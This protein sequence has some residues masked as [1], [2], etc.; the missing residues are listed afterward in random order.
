[1]QQDLGKPGTAQTLYV[2]GAS[3]P[4]LLGPMATDGPE[5]TYF[6][7]HFVGGNT[8]M[9]A[10]IGAAVDRAGS[11]EPYPELSI[12]SFTSADKHSPYANAFWTNV[13][14]R[15]P[16]TQHAR[17]AW[18]RLRNVLDLELATPQDVVR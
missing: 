17:L 16:R 7:H 3:V 9:P 14:D 2:G 6:S 11:V 10:M 8:Y 12:F 4:P 15:G 13:G 1:M 18:D 5:R